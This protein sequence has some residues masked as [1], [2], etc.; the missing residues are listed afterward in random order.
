MADLLNLSLNSSI[1]CHA[2]NRDRTQLAISLNSKEVYIY[3]KSDNTWQLAQ[4]LTE[5]SARVLSIDWAP[6]SNRI[7]TC[8]SD[9]NA[10]VWS[11]DGRVWKPELVVLRVQRAATCVKWSP[12]EKKFAVGCGSRCICVCYFE[13]LQQFWVAK[14]IKKQLRSTTLCLD[15]HPNNALLA[16]GG[17]DFK[18]RIFGAH[19]PDVDGPLTETSRWATSIKAADC[20][21]EFSTNNSGWVYSCGFNFDG[22]ILAF[23]SHDSTIY[24]VDCTRNPQELVSQRTPFL[25]FLSMKF[26]SNT[27]IIVAGHDCVPLVYG[28]SGNKISLLEKLD[29]SPTKQ[30][31]SVATAKDL[32]GNRERINMD[33]SVNT[34]INSIHQNSIN[35]VKILNQSGTK[36]T[37]VSTTGLDG[38]IVIWDLE[39]LEKRFGNLRIR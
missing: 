38:N 2:W 32:F 12:N 4:T 28:L 20:I 33:Q 23:V 1:S 3:S 16:A 19:I 34:T 18:C 13:P 6:Q 17:S 7:V 10:Y 26:I 8:G 21:H 30:K 29:V 24:M 27:S 36:V 11:L 39:A 35:D 14:H 37:Q 31:S 5:H 15:W 9:K 22:N 25:P